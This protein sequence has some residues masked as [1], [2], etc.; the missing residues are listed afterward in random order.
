MEPREDLDPR[1]LVAG[2]TGVDGG[3]LPC[4]SRRSRVRLVPVQPGLEPV[5]TA[6]TVL[7]I[8]L[9][10]DGND[11][12]DRPGG[13]LGRSIRNAQELQ[14][15]LL[16]ERVRIGALVVGGTGELSGFCKDSLRVQQPARFDQRLAE[17]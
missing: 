13:F 2:E 7:V 10:E 17:L 11:R 1:M 9:L 6:E 5:R 15:L 14:E 3:P 16:H 4:R 8:A 12:L